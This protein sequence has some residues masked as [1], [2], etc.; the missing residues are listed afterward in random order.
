MEKLEAAMRQQAFSE[1]F[2]ESSRDRRSFIQKV[3]LGAAGLAYGSLRS[4]RKAAAAAVDPGKTDVSFVIGSDRRENVYQTLLPFKDQ[5]EEGIRDKKVIIKTNLVDP[6]THLAATHPDA[7]RGVL[8]FLAPIYKER[9]IVG[10]STGRPGGTYQCLVNHNYLPLKDEYKVELVDLNYNDVGT[11]W[12]MD[13][14]FHPLSIAI[15]DKFLDPDYYIISLTRP[16]THNGAFVTLS[17][18][19]IVMGSPINVLTKKTRF[20]RGQKTLMHSGG[21]KGLNFNMFL[22]AQKVRPQFSVIDGLVGMEGNGASWG[23]P[24]YH[25]FALAGPDMLAVDRVTTELMGVNFEDVG[26]LLYL[27]WAGEG[28]ADLDKINIIGPDFRPYIIPYKMH[29][30]IETHYVWK[31]G[32]IIGRE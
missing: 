27:A 21:N 12:I 9:V 4:F 14:N 8:D 5:I 23:T 28:Q 1:N 25:G 31:E 16:K 3:A 29:D 22:L 7:V 24:V 32:L 6:Q 11:M 20:L 13:Q 26:Y 17:V 30:N 19:N 15:I 18:K 10:D 2:I